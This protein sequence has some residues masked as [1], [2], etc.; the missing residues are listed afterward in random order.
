MVSLF[1]NAAK[2]IGQAFRSLWSWASDCPW[3]SAFGIGGAAIGVY[4]LSVASDA[5][6]AEVDRSQ[7]SDSA[8]IGFAFY[9]SG[10]V[11]VSALLGFII[12]A[13]LGGRIHLGLERVTDTSSTHRH[14]GDTAD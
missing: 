1:V 4:L 2:A 14:I 12:G 11:A 5:Y 7:M 8:Q 10:A 9:S 6:L 3:Q 13:A